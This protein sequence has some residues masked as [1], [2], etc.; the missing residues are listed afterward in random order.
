MPWY[1]GHPAS[2]NETA[3]TIEPGAAQANVTIPTSGCDWVW[4]A[5]FGG[6]MFASGA[7]DLWFGQRWPALG[8]LVLGSVM[9]AEGLWIRTFGVDLRPQS[10]N[11]RGLRRRSIP[12]QDVQAVIHHSRQG[13]WGV[14]LILERGKPVTLRAPTTGWGFGAADYERDFHRIGQWWL[15]HRGES[16]RPVH[17]EAPLPPVGLDLGRVTAPGEL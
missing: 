15:A 11:V 5:A 17:P 4:I 9:V 2:E 14:R 6:S 13:T 8:R 16:W 3:M 7:P 12:W 10:A 1:V